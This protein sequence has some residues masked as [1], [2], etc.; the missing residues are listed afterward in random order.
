MAKQSSHSQ[1]NGDQDIRKAERTEGVIALNG[2]RGCMTQPH[3]SMCN[4]A[5]RLCVAFLQ[6][7]V[8]RALRP[9]LYT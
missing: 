8:K 9:S 6:E 5:G 7:E 1:K 3:P 4:L 2:G